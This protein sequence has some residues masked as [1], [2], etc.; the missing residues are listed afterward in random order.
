[1]GCVFFSVFP[2]RFWHRPRFAADITN[3]GTICLNNRLA[4]RDLFTTRVPHRSNAVVA[5]RLA[6]NQLLSTTQLVAKL[7]DVACKPAAQ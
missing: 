1:M 6:P 2:L 5:Q 4:T 3:F 7:A